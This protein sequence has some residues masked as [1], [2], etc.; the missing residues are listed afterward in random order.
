MFLHLKL[1]LKFENICETF[2]LYSR[3]L[4]L[5]LVE[6]EWGILIYEQYKK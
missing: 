1:V 2:S 5:D 3:Y 6:G 4:L